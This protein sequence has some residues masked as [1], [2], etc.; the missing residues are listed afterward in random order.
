M[1]RG[2]A[3]GALLIGV[4]AISKLRDRP[5]GHGRSGS[6]SVA[7]ENLAKRLDHR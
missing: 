2:F 3:F 6:N 7:I 4:P 5:L 1:V